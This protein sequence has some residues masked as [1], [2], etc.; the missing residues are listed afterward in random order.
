[1]MSNLNTFYK[2]F[3]G[4]DAV[5]FL[6]FPQ[7][8]PILLGSLSTI[9]HSVYREKKP[10]PLLGKIN[11]GGYTRGMRSIAGTMVFTLVNQHLVEDLKEQIPYLEAHGKLKADELPFFDIMIVCA[12]EYGAAS[13]LYI[14]GAEFYEDGQ[15]I[16]VQDIYIENTFS[17][18][19]RDIDDFSRINPIVQSGALGSNYT[20]E[21]L[22]GYA[23]SKSDYDDLYSNLASAKTSSYGKLKAAQTALKAEGYEVNLNGIA[24]NETVLAIKDFQ[25]KNKLNVTGELTDATYSL[26]TDKDSFFKNAAMSQLDE[27]LQKVIIQIQNK[28]G[29]YVYSNTDKDNIIGITK[30]L[31]DYIGYDCGEFIKISFYGNTGYIAKEDTKAPASNIIVDYSEKTESGKMYSY[32]I[33][34]FN[35]DLIGTSVKVNSD[36]EFRISAIAYFKNNASTFACRYYKL[37]EGESRELLLSYLSTAFIYNMEEKSIPLKV[38]FIITP[39]GGNSVKWTVKLKER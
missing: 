23:F 12:N 26:L 28:N 29:A 19:A 30:Y 16:S 39:I 1:M 7:S 13:Q 11:T 10:V 5:A 20:V 15:V 2:T 36:V 4:S 14:Y 24:D 25:S 3:S 27:V 32:Y 21:T 33:D 9:S 34:E 22:V 6:I 17:F 35:P 18:V 37:K 8:K 38:D 31:D